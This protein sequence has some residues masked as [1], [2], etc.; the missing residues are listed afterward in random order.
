MAQTK[1]MGQQFRVFENSD[2]IDGAV[3]CQVTI[4]QN[5]EDGST[6]DTTGSFTEETVESRS[7]QVQVED[8]NG[9]YTALRTLLSAIKSMTAKTVG[10]DRTSGTENGT[11]QNE[12]WAKSGQAYLS[13]LTI[14]ANNRQAIQVTRQ[15]TGSGELS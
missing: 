10:F 3:S 5:M 8:K 11:A 14:V 1:L 4:T 2:K 7:W 15:Y 12:T 9:T 13:D 6:K